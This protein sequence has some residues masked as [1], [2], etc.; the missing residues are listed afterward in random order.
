MRFAGLLL[1]AFSFSGTLAAQQLTEAQRQFQETIT[2]QC[3]Q[4]SQRLGSP[5]D[6]AQGYCQCAFSGVA[7]QIPDAQLPEVE[8]CSFAGK[9]ASSFCQKLLMTMEKQALTCVDGNEVVKTNFRTAGKTACATSAGLGGQVPKDKLDAYCGCSMDYVAQGMTAQEI[10]EADFA[11][12]QGKT[13]AASRKMQ[14]LSEKAVA[15]CQALL[16]K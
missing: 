1:A 5:P 10:V 11:L 13:S 3:I 2:Q 12:R 7:A 14:T 6:Q 15:Q 9:T 16:T 8:R 4:T